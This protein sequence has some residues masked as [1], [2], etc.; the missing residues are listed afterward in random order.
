M[1][2]KPPLEPGDVIVDPK[3]DQR[4]YIER[5]RTLEMLGVPIEQQAQISLIHIS[6]EIYSVPALEVP[7]FNFD[8]SAP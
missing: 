2:Y 3:R 6:D 5:T 1:L 4:F 8:L 7:S